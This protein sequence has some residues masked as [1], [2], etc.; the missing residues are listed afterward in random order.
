MRI[1]SFRQ[2]PNTQR[3]DATDPD[4]IIDDARY[5]MLVDRSEVKRPGDRP[6]ILYFERVPN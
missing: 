6:K 2:N 4:Y 3:W 5:V 1:R